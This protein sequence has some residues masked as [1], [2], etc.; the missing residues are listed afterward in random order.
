M[1]AA[2]VWDF[3]YTV[4][5]GRDELGYCWDAGHSS[6]RCTEK[7]G[8][9][10]D[11][12]AVGYDYRC[13]S[14]WIA[15]NRAL[16]LSGHGD[17]LIHVNGVEFIGSSATVLVGDLEVRIERSGHGWKMTIAAPDAPVSVRIPADGTDAK[18]APIG[19]F[20]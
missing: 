5:Q 20:L 6:Y 10:G 18:P 2:G 14:S 11:H 3:D 9:S 1:S 12:R 13:H 7:V 4:E 15:T 17:D 16:I 19:E 8:H